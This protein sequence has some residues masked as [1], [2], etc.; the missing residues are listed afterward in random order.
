MPGK[1]AVKDDDYYPGMGIPYPL[2]GPTIGECSV[3]FRPEMA[4]VHGT[5]SWSEPCS[6]RVSSSLHYHQYNLSRCVAVLSSLTHYQPFL[7]IRRV[8]QGPRVTVIGFHHTCINSRS[9]LTLAS[10]FRTVSSISVVLERRM[11]PT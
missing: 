2:S 11:V 8:R 7:S 5:V 4:D 9:D 6:V 10:P 1:G 3:L